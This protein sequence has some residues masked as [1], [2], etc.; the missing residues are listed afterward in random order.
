M[1]LDSWL[2]CQMQQILPLSET[3]SNFNEEK[4]GF[5]PIKFHIREFH[6]VVAERQQRNVPKCDPQEELLF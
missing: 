1:S 5:L 3:A 6:V 2:N 4:G